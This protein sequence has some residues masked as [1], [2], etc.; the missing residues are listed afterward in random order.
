MST[1]NRRL[2]GLERAMRITDDFVPFNVVVVLRVAG[3]LAPSALR[4]ALDALQRRHPLLR[5]GAVGP[6]SKPYF[7]FDVAG[8]I[9]LE[10]Q[11]RA[12]DDSWI[13]V[14]EVELARK[15][16]L[17]AGPLMRCVYLGGPSRADI[18][19][20]FQHMIL[21]ASS[22][23]RL[24]EEL[25]GSCAGE[26]P[27]EGGIA[28][29]GRVPAS[30]WFP[31]EFTGARFA[32]AVAAFMGRQLTDEMWFR[33][34]SRGVRKPSIGKHGNCRILPIRFSPALTSAL[35]QASRRHRITLNSILG[36]GLIAA[37]QH[38]CYPGPR[39]PLRHLV[40]ADL[41]PRL[42]TVPPESMLG[43]FLTMVRMTVM[44]K[45]D[46]DLWALAQDIQDATIRAE[47]SGERF[48]AFALSP[49][50][51]KM[52]LGQRMFRWSATAFSYS[53]PPDLRIDYGTFELT[54]VH[55]F[56]SNWTTGPEYSALAR[57]FRGELCW[58][59]LYL[60]CDM[61]DATAREIARDL[62]RMLHEAT[63]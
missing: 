5:A 37:L 32:R 43:V 18:V 23:V 46:G 30:A 21:D 45:R 19:L 25:L 47:R 11:D 10:T 56:P 49:G 4:S 28:D 8:P 24:I 41:R 29:E 9:P 34:H 14:A 36:A 58:D 16:D 27:P 55:A 1:H 50:V 48:L 61:D 35:I 13:A 17:A 12:S 53:G 22:A 7:H 59:I 60:D 38:R 31:P 42:R 52:V 15:F 51:I 20:T 54:G 40:F 26:P 33:W 44:V 2:V 39:A 62:E 3:A 63:C 57:L 6:A